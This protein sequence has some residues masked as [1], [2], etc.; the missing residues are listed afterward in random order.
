MPSVPGALAGSAQHRAYNVSPGWTDSLGVL[1]GLV[2]ARSGKDV[3]I[4]I[5]SDGEGLEYTAD[6]SRL[7]RELP[8]LQFAPSDVAID[9]LYSWYS[10]RRSDIDRA[11]LDIDA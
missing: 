3:P 8:N 10:D 9:R 5:G 2:A 4:Q 11:R 1:A 7:R 6:S